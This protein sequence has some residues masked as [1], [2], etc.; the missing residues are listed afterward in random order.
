MDW[1]HFQLILTTIIVVVAS[2]SL[3]FAF[4]A[5]FMNF[6][7][8]TK[9]EPVKKDI[10]KLEAGQ[11]KLEAGQ[12]K[13]EKNIAKLEAGQVKLEK[14]MDGIESKLDQLLAKA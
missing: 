5:F 9:I 10:A 3:A 4:F 6:L 8:N 11:A 7:L 13:L 2:F 12:V 1:T 14:R